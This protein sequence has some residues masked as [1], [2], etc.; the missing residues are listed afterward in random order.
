M[1]ERDL[2]EHLI[3]RLSAELTAG[4]PLTS[5]LPS[6]SRFARLGAIAPRGHV[7][8]RILA[9]AAATVALLA[10]AGAGPTQARQ[11]I[12]Q[13]V[14][15][16]VDDVQR[17]NHHGVTTGAQSPKASHPS[18]GQASPRTPT[19]GK[20]P[21]PSAKP[22]AHE[23]PKPSPHESPVPGHSPEGDGPG[24]PSPSPGGDGGDGG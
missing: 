14:G 2:P 19:A 16:F 3:A 4:A 12:G 10:V 13:S 23:S 17:P 5:P 6:Q 1:P 9:A 21:E 11:W 20:S 8:L 7:R 22:D 15:S 18:G 24:S